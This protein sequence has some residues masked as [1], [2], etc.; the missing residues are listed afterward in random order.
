MALISRNVWNI[1]MVGTIQANQTG[2]PMAASVKGSQSIKKKMYEYMKDV[3]T[4]HTTVSCC[5][6]VR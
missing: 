1:N 6:L 5:C 2:A 3:A 4:Q